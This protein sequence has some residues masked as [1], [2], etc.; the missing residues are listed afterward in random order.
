MVKLK[1]LKINKYRNV[2]PGTELQFDDGFNL[3]LGQNASGKTALL[4]LISMVCR[5]VFKE[6]EHEEFALEYTLAADLHSIEVIV[7]NARQTAQDTHSFWVGE[8]SITVSSSTGDPLDI[9]RSE[10]FTSPLPHHRVSL[11]NDWS[12]VA[13]ALTARAKNSGGFRNELLSSS[14]RFD[15]TLDCFAAM[16][17]RDSGLRGPA[18]PPPAYVSWEER[19]DKQGGVSA[20]NSAYVPPPLYQ[21]IQTAFRRPVSL[22]SLDE[23]AKDLASSLANVLD[24]KQVKIEPLVKAR[25]RSVSTDYHLVEGFNFLLTRGEGTLI[26]HDRWSYGQKRLVAFFYY[27]ALNPSIVVADEL[28]NGLHHRWIQACMEAIG[29]R[30][31]FLTSQNPLLFDYIPD[32]ESAEQVQARFVTCKTEVVEGGEELVWQNLSEEDATMFFEA[33]QREVQPIGEILIT[34]G[35][36]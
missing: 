15:E 16:T 21:A 36:W 8:Y 30:Q 27:L 34:R 32:F 1:R 6:I 17:G 12:F 20:V 23:A 28:V 2:R 11:M 4:S 35:L 5:S 33:Y 18:T 22:I 3:V 31:A 19:R 13:A 25:D 14:F 29:D 24:G 7:S 26:H 10:D 9:I